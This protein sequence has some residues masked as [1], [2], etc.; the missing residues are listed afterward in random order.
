MVYEAVGAPGYGLQVAKDLLGNLNE[1]NVHPVVLR[2]YR[3]PTDKLK[4]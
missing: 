4:R 3:W 2:T 1:I